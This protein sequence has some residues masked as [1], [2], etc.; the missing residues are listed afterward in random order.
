MADRLLVDRSGRSETE[1]VEMTLT[2]TTATLAR[3]IVCGMVAAALAMP[4]IADARVPADV[5]G[6][7]AQLDLRS[8]DTR[9]A[10]NDAVHARAWSGYQDLR[11]PD[12]RDAV[13]NRLA[14]SEPAA[15]DAKAATPSGFDWDSALIGAAAGVALMLLSLGATIQ[16]RRLTGRG[17]AG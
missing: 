14:G 6:A 5:P 15:I 4:G 12:A 17:L 2:K 16:S 13:A 1:G 7:T 9:T 11:S 8:P 10:A 3:A